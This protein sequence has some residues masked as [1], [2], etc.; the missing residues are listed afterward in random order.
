MIPKYLSNFIYIRSELITADNKYH[1]EVLYEAFDNLVKELR[2]K[3][4]YQKCNIMI[5]EKGRCSPDI[6]SIVLN[7][8]QFKV[9]PN[10]M[11]LGNVLTFNLDD[12]T[13]IHSKLN[14]FYRSFN[15]MYRSFTGMNIEVLLC[16]FNSLCSPQYGIPLWTSFNI[17]NKQYFRSFEVAYNNAL[18]SMVGCP[19]YAS[20]HITAEI[21]QQLMLRHGVSVIQ[22]RY[23]KSI[24][25]KNNP[26]FNMN[27]PIIKNSHSF[28]FICKYFNDLYNINALDTPIDIVISRINWVQLHEP[29][30]RYCSFYLS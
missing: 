13:D 15:S 20:S 8:Q 27:L 7:N 17:F 21:C 4:N 26:L 30:S 28:L 16:L 11:Y 14:S 24:I 3:V 19:R 29:R 12:E 23:I 22:A 9:V 5:F 10:F 1:L 18:K 2:L 25:S 6:E